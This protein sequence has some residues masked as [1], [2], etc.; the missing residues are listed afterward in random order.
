MIPTQDDSFIIGVFIGNYDKGGH[1]VSLDLDLYPAFEEHPGPDKMIQ[2]LFSTVN[3]LE[4]SGQNYGRLFRND[5]LRVEFEIRQNVENIK[6]LFTTTG[7]GG[8]GNG[9]E[10]NQRL[11]QIFLDDTEIF[12]ILP[13]RTDCGAYRMDNPAS[14]NFGTGL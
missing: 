13:W 6:L 8:W 5:T 9:D 3:I 7:H 12:S 1:I 2:P 11:N 10:F 14:G 4:M